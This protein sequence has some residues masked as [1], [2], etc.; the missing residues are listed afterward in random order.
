MLSFP[1]QYTWIPKLYEQIQGMCINHLLVIIGIIQTLPFF[2][3]K[4]CIKNTCEVQEWVYRRADPSW[5]RQ[6]RLQWAIPAILSKTYGSKS[7]KKTYSEPDRRSWKI[8]CLPGPTSSPSSA[9]WDMAGR[10]QGSG[11]ANLIKGNCGAQRAAWTSD[12]R[13]LRLAVGDCVNYF[14]AP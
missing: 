14:V 9:L 13:W 5:F 11:E 3:G 6:I 10:R 2:L 8:S 1:P 4:T 12:S 7:G